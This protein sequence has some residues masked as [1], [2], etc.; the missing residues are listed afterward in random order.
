MPIV[1]YIREHR[2]FIQ[3]ASDEKLTANERLLWYALMEIFNQRADGHD[4]PGDFIRIG[5]DRVLTLCPMGFDTMAKARNGLKQRGLIDFKPGDKNKANPAYK[6]NYFAPESN[7]ILSDNIPYNPADNIPDNIADNTQDNRQGNIRD[8]N[9]NRNN[10]KYYTYTG[11]NDDEEDEEDV[12][13]RARRAELTGKIRDGFLR[14]FGRNPTPI[15]TDR[16]VNYA[17]RLS[18]PVETV[19]KAMEIAA[20][21]GPSSPS[22]YSMGI[23]EEW[24][25]NDVMTPEQYDQYKVLKDAASGKNLFGT[26]DREEDFRRMKEAQ[27]ERIRQNSE[28]G[29]PCKHTEEQLAEG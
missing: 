6:I 9:P 10:N 27:R 14:L 19:L 5:N 18:F 4:W 7:P 15:E 8:I 12:I 13:F 20:G 17:I 21:K 25:D 28:A 23:L 11:F 2:R 26:G 24:W 22:D 29:I 3:Y 1:N 16:M